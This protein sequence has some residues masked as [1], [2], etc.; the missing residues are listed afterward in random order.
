MPPVIQKSRCVG[1]MNCVNICPNDTFGL[2]K[3]GVKVPQV[4]YPKECKH[5]NACVLECPK[6]AISLR[7]PV[8]QMMV[9]YDPGR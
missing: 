6:E 9:F 3:P 5:C 7:F 2:Q 4:Q 1:C 8:P